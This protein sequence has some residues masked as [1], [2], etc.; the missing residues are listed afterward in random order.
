MGIEYETQV[1]I[2]N[3]ICVDVYIPK[4]NIIIQWDGNYW[5]GKGLLYEQLD[6]GQK[7]RRDLDISQ[8]AY[9]KKCGF[10]E[11]RFWEDEVYKESDKVYDD[12]QRAIQQIAK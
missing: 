8:D 12:I 2:N 7:Q 3:K 4:Y 5:H 9:L 10:T 1:L 11:L 6:K